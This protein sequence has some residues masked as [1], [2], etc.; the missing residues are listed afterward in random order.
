MQLSISIFFETYHINIQYAV[1]RIH[2][3][4]ESEG[5][6]ISIPRSEPSDYPITG[7]LKL[8]SVNR[9]AL[10]IF[11]VIFDRYG[12]YHILCRQLHFL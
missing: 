11:K 7:F 12:L 9:F 5:K 4:H 10:A 8:L 3:L 6:K 1:T 2:W